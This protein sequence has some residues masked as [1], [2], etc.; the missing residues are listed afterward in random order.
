MR[1]RTRLA[2]AIAGLAVAALALTGCNS[3]SPGDPSDGAGD[4][5]D[6]PLWE[7]ASDVQLEGSPTFDAMTKRGKVVI[8]VKN[9][10][11][12][13]GYEDAASGER[14][15]F[16]IDIARWIAASLG[17]DED[18]IEYQTIPSANREQAIVNGDIDYYVGTYSIT[19]KRKEQIDFAG[20]YL[21]TGQGL[22]VAADNKDING[23]DDLA[24]KIVCSVTGST[25]LQRIRDE[26]NPGDTVEYDTYS[27]CVDQL[28]Q[29]SVDAITTDEAILAGYVAQ[30]PDE[31]K[32]AGEPFSEERYGVGIAKGDSELQAHINELFTDGGDVWQALFDE[33]LAPAGIKGEQPAVD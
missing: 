14:S 19:D 21:I 3:G 11:P 25:P 33:H 5:S 18:Q 30:Q 12:G 17:F 16:D 22:L 7:V 20:P 9:D 26:Y 6:A 31:L 27:Q 24:G 13:L 23:P 8:G 32:I 28:V 2:G 1:S 29:G 4:A 15:G 10:Q